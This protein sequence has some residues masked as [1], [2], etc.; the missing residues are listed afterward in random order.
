M[1]VPVQTPQCQGDIIIKENLGRGS[2]Q[3]YEDMTM[4]EE[5]ESVLTELSNIPKAQELERQKLMKKPWGI[6]KKAPVIVSTEL[7]LRPCDWC[8]MQG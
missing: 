8:K 3:G 1:I 2:K 4:D 5:G 6:P 7:R